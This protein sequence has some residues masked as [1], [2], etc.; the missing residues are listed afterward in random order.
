[1]HSLLKTFIIFALTAFGFLIYSGLF[2]GVKTEYITQPQRWIIYETHIG[3]YKN[4]DT[5]LEYVEGSLYMEPAVL[6]DQ[7]FMLYFDDPD[8]VESKNLR[9]VMGVILDYA[10][11]ELL[12]YLGKRYKVA[13]L[14]PCKNISV[15]FPYIN[16]VS[17]I[18][19]KRRS[20]PVLKKYLKENLLEGLPIL[21]VYDST[22]KTITYSSPLSLSPEYL[23]GI[24]EHKFSVS[25]FD[26]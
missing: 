8:E 17:K 1:M 7:T 24:F 2:A 22:D 19:G 20:H 3:D 6:T 14:P 10:S 5:V 25:T 23:E 21:E 11:P 12:N 26:E 4:S 18:I 13:R 9:S 15:V 16:F